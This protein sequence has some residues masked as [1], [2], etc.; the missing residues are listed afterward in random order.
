MKVS[1]LSKAA[2][3]ALSWCTKFTRLNIPTLSSKEVT[4]SNIYLRDNS[5][6]T[7]SQHPTSQQRLHLIKDIDLEVHP[8]DVRLTGDASGFKVIWSDRDESSYGFDWIRENVLKTE[9][10][11]NI[12]KEPWS[13]RE[14]SREKVSL[15]Y[16]DVLSNTEALS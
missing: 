15:D 14:M 4:L 3:P 12:R 10:R 13:S 6:S 11:S 7:R 8:V 5:Q 1:S 9:L 2:A 16:K